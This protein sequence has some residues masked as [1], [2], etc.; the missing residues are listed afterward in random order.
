M[1][2]QQPPSP[3]TAWCPTTKAPLEQLCPRRAGPPGAGRPSPA[4]PGP[5]LCRRRAHRRRPQLLGGGG[6]SRGHGRQRSFGAG[7]VA[8]GTGPHLSQRAEHEFAGTQCGLMDQLIS[9]AGQEAHALLIDLQSITW[10]AVPLPAD[11][12][13]SSA[14]RASAVAGQF[15]L[16]RAP[17][18]V[19][20]ECPAPGGA[21]AARPG[22]G[23]L[24]GSGRRAAAHCSAAAAA[25]WST[26][27]P[28]P[29]KRPRPCVRGDTAVWPA[30]GRVSRQPAGPVRG[31]QRGA[32]PDGR[33][34]PG[35]ARLLGERA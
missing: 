21:L 31:E 3:W 15:G 19:R 35:P 32:G 17:R 4:R 29:S 26:R 28:A 5:G 16:Q 9:A 33:P 13:S 24:R 27:T 23:D 11:N 20:G 6:G 1:G 14:T 10:Q 25:T 7:P 22:R 2:G 8:H 12:Q 30:H 18:P 34:G